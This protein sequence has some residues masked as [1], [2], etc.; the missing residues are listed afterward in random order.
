MPLVSLL[1]ASGALDRLPGDLPLD[2]IIDDGMNHVLNTAQDRVGYDV[3]SGALAAG[4]DLVQ[5][6]VTVVEA[7]TWCTSNSSCLGFCFRGAPNSTGV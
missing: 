7:E 5:L 1:R 6:N 4:G 2:Q 3:S